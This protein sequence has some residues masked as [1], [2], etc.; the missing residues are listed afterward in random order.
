MKWDDIDRAWIGL[1]ALSAG[2]TIVAASLQ[3]GLDHRLIGALI[4]F[5][6]LLKA[7]LVLAHYLGLSQAPRCK[8]GFNVFLTLFCLLL[9]TLYLIPGSIA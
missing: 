8:Y 9:L 1:I 4:L 7:R 2:S 3:I 6:A 5:L